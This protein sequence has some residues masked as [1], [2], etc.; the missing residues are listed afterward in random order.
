MAP[1]P[2][3]LPSGKWR[4]R[5][6]DPHGARR[7]RTFDKK[8]DADRWA[9]EVTRLRQ[10]GELERLTPRNF[11]LTDLAKEWLDGPARSVAPSTRKTNV[12]IIKSLIV[13]RIGSAQVASL[14]TREVERW[15]AEMEADGLPPDRRRRGLTALRSLMD[16]A[17]IW[18]YARSNPA[19][20]AKLPKKPPT[21]PIKP[22][23]PDTIEK[24]R[25]YLLE[26]GRWQDAVI[27]SLMAYAGL[28]PGE[29]TRAKWQHMGNRT[30]TVTASKTSRSRA[31]QLME[32]VQKD[33]QEWS[34]ACGRPA[35]GLIYPR[36]LAGDWTDTTY[37]NWN[38]RIFKPAASAAGAA[39]ATPKVLRASFASLMHAA[40]KPPVWVAAQ[41]GHS[42][43]VHMDHYVHIIEDV[44]PDTRLDPVAMIVSA[45]EEHWPPIGHVADSG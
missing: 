20:G 36:P 42:L 33:L 27:V 19:K 17:V 24:M 6:T 21:E 26:R 35:N 12:E 3:K 15:L 28:R 45:R 34:L 25:V 43:R 31:V 5:W 37:R 44:D 8:A 39:D 41:M 11:T 22:L 4:V 18:E 29:A 38:R 14:S 7:S 32:P 40:H 16:L 30:L 13:R 23:S 1:T 10:R 9:S 2:T